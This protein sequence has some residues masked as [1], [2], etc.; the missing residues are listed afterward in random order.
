MELP[1]CR[2]KGRA[3]RRP[4]RRSPNILS[5]HRLS[6]A[7][8]GRWPTSACW[9]RSWRARCRA[10]ARTMRRML[11]RWAARR[12]RT[13]SSSS[14]PTPSIVGPGAPILLPPSSTEVHYEGELAVVIGRPCKDVPAGKA[15][16]V[17]LGYTVAQRRHG[18]RSAAPRRPVD[19]GQGLRH[20][21][22]AG[23]V[24]RDRTRP[25]RPEVRTELDGEI[26]QA[27]ALRLLL[28]DIAEGHRVGLRRHDTAAGRR[29]SHRHARGRRA[30]R[31]RPDSR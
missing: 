18:A 28:H 26:M 8:A 5:A 14:S 21:L 11:R 29:D 12:R 4:R 3:T 23:T 9:R 2:S 6:P 13:R 17:V 1:S 15:L 24:D 19:A 27:A 22:P 10:S 7:A 31:R 25:V 30:D 20:V 16:D